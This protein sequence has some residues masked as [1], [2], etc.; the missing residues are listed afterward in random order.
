MPFNFQLGRKPET[1][2][3]S[4]SPLS[5]PSST[6]RAKERGGAP[7]LARVSGGEGE[8]DGDSEFPVVAG[9]L[10][11]WKIKGMCFWTFLLVIH[12]NPSRFFGES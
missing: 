11:N 6:A 2:G 10:P 5:S 1:T 4:E 12:W 7:S 9:F 3:N 8:E